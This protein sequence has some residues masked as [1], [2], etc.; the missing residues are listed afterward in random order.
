MIRFD[1][2]LASRGQPAPVVERWDYHV[3]EGGYARITIALLGLLILAIPF[4][5][6]EAWA[7]YA[8]GVIVVAYMLPAFVL[9]VL[10]PFPGWHVLWD[11]V[12]QPGL[13]R[14]VFLDLFF[15]AL[16][17]VALGLSFREILGRG[18]SQPRA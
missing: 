2:P 17:A 13:A 10:V 4:R 8:M 15:P 5:K 9:R 16:M 11:W 14:D 7:W 6:G 12:F 1:Q 18:G 3:H